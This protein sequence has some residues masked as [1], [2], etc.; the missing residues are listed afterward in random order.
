MKLLHGYA[1]Y[2]KK[3]LPAILQAS[4]HIASILSLISHEKGNC[5]S[6]FCLSHAEV[7]TGTRS[8]MMPLSRD[9]KLSYWSSTISWLWKSDIQRRDNQVPSPVTSSK[10]E[11]RSTRAITSERIGV[12]DVYTFCHSAFLNVPFSWIPVPLKAS[13]RNQSVAFIPARS[14]FSWSSLWIRRDKTVANDKSGR[15]KINSRRN[16][17]KFE[18]V[19]F[20]WQ[21]INSRLIP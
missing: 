21:I 7:I 15:K 2:L 1:E 5:R 9:R 14:S 3:C 18:H 19:L 4:F 20:K 11:S 12:T 6:K 10:L 13:K 16:L 8:L 17:I